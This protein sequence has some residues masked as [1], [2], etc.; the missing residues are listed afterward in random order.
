MRNPKPLLSIVIAT[1][2]EEKN[3]KDCLKSIK[4]IADEIIIVDG[5]STD[6]TPQIAKKMGATIISVPNKP[7]DFHANKQ[8]GIDKAKG[9]WILQLDADERVTK[10][11]AK[12]IE[13]LIKSNTVLEGYAIP[14]K[15]W[16]LG[17]FLT[18]G[19]AYPDPVVRLFKQGKGSFSNQT[20]I[21]NSITTSNVHAQIQIASEVGI[22]TQDLIHYGDL[23]IER[24]LK[25][26]NRYTTL[27]AENLQKLGFET[28]LVKSIDYLVAKPIYWFFKRYLRHRGY[29]DGFQG[30]LFALLSAL[31]YPIIYLKI[32][33]K[34]K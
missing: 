15:N 7:D 11:L 25:R 24:Y 33:E 8:L 2:N 34:T 4:D 1:F 10:P 14:R 3:I 29:V 19:G 20:I 23:E 28:N 9:E 17:R 21:D 6:K 26:L 32:W 12:E 5:Q 30:F 22:L 27:E 31:H 18:K 13:S 16:F